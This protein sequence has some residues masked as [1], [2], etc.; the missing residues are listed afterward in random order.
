MNDDE[1]FEDEVSRDEVALSPNEAADPQ[2]IV[3]RMI[4]P[5]LL[6]K[7]EV[8]SYRSAAT[9]LALSHEG[10]FE[11]LCDALRD[12]AITE[13][14]IRTA[15]GNESEIPKLL[16]ASLRPKEWR[17]TIIRGDLKVE[18][19][20]K[21]YVTTSKRGKPLAKPRY[22]KMEPEII[23]RAK[24]LDGHK[25]DYVKGKVAFDLEWNS[26]DQTFDRDLYAFSAFAQTGVVDVGVLVTRGVEMTEFIKG[27][28]P[29]LTKSGKIEMK[30]GTP[31]TT[32]AK[33]GASTTWMGKL[34]Y[35]LNAGRNGACPVLVFGITPRCVVER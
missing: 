7:Y 22:E 5:D 4:P 26:K 11:E 35:R 9:I 18:K 25:V 23:T 16:S 34:L 13:T 24:Y 6:A 12:F 32:A 15:G 29:A 10:L 20:A 17:E 19:I 31:R 1:T 2:E 28:G 3:A 30:D 33:Y 14:M 21:R 8:H 27:L